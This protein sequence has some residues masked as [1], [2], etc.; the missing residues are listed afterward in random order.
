MVVNNIVILYM[1]GAASNVSTSYVRYSENRDNVLNIVANTDKAALDLCTSPYHHKKVLLGPTICDGNGA[2]NQPSVGREAMNESVDSIIKLLVNYGCKTLV[3]VAGLGGGTGTGSTEFVCDNMDL[4]RSQGI[5]VIGFFTTPLKIEGSKR[6]RAAR[7]AASKLS[8]L[9]SY[10][11]IN[12]NGIRNK[13]K[14][15]KTGLTLKQ[16]FNKLN[17]VVSDTID[18]FVHIRT[19]VGLVNI[20]ADDISET[21]Q[22]GEIHPFTYQTDKAISL[23]DVAQAF[24]QH[25]QTYYY[26]NDTP[27]DK[28]IIAFSGK[29][30]SITLGSVSDVSQYFT[31][32]GAELIYGIFTNEEDTNSKVAIIAAITN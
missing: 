32:K 1:G 7:E 31:D 3:I 2:G 12:S 4:F 30:S 29:E 21:I 22:N 5:S 11:L 9:D 13:A 24:E 28:V 8:S 10:C 23:K 16:Y 6:M 26:A 20:D 27:Y 14:A 17:K 15:G 18:N 25:V 19:S